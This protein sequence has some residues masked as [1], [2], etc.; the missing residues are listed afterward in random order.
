MWESLGTRGG[1]NRRN[2]RGQTP[3]VPRKSK[4]TWD[5]ISALTPLI[6]GVAI[7]GVGALFT[8]I[9]NYRQLQL[10]QITALEKLRPLLTS[11]KAEDRE[12]G[13]ASFVALGYEEVAI[14][15]IQINKDQS[16]RRA[17]Q[18]IQKLGNSTQLQQSAA[19]ALKSLDETKKLITKLEGGETKGADA[20]AAAGMEMADKLGLKTKLA[21]ALIASEVVNGGP[22]RTQ[23]LVDATTKFLGGNPVSGIDE[24]KW[25][26]QYLRQMTETNN[27]YLKQIMQRRVSEFESL[28]KNDDWELRTY[29]MN[30]SN[31]LFQ[32]TPASGRP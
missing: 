1:N 14:K 3:I 16:G 19:Q 22:D 30:P 28:I 6:L 8:Q 2:N 15:I 27:L 32:G 21:R 9:Y 4:D 24:R 11:E 7:T 25:V 20:W 31:T 26:E 13:Y 5:K 29:Q 23:L 12:F 10:N 18:D 17:L